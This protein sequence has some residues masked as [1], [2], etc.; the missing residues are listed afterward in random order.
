MKVLFALSGS[1]AAFKAC[2]LI[3][4]WKKQGHDIQVIATKGALQFIGKATLEGLT[5][6]EVLT[7]NFHDGHMMKHISLARWCDFFILCPASANTIARLAQGRS[8]DLLGS[9]YLALEKDRKFFLCPAM[10]S[11]MYSHPAV[12]N[13]LQ[14]LQSRGA[15]ILPTGQG[16]LACGEVG[17]GRL[18]EP[19]EIDSY[20]R[21]ELERRTT[22]PKRVL[23]TAGGTTEPIDGVRS[24]TNT[25]S[26]KTA[27]RIAEYL[28]R[29]GHDV[30]FLKNVNVDDPKGQIQVSTFKTFDDLQSG[31]E[32]ALSQNHFDFVIHAAAVSDYSVKQVQ[33][34]NGDALSTQEKIPSGEALHV[35]LQP[36]PKLIDR[37]KF[38]SANKNVKLIGFK[39]TNTQDSTKQSAAVQRLLQQSGA[40]WVVHND[41]NQIGLKGAESHPFRL[42]NQSQQVLL[43]GSTKSELCEALF[44]LLEETFSSEASYDLMS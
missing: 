22:H 11:E 35:V 16:L 3:S 21:R 18:L 23:I 14:I 28:A 38:Q 1:I 5:G 13:N 41:L 24:I 7:D 39:L 42:F 4:H 25:S 10:N 33:T 19:L 36:N 31:L 17:Y 8:E 20:I 26:G 43:A 30:Q 29:Y 9:L 6:H 32:S 27:L 37:I 44:D 12:E 34:S 15:H 40:D 2:E